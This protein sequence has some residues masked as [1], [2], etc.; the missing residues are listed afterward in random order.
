MPGSS[1]H[2]A[3]ESTDPDVDAAVAALTALAGHNIPVDVQ[4]LLVAGDPMRGI[5]PGA[6]SA[7][8]KAAIQSYRGAVTAS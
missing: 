6:L 2:Y 1:H 5:P 4:E 3:P 7:C 8:V